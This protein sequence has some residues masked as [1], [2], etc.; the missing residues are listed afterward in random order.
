MPD[1]NDLGAVSTIGFTRAEQIVIYLVVIQVIVFV[2]PY[3]QY[4]S[5]NSFVGKVTMVYP[6]IL[7]S[8]SEPVFAH[9]GGLL[10]VRCR[11]FA[12]VGVVTVIN[13]AIGETAV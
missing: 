3:L 10:S 4:Q 8:E 13:H 6:V 12:L 2:E 1:A 7:T 9:G 5:A 11:L